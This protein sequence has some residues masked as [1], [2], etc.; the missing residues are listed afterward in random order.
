MIFPFYSL[1]LLYIWWVK[2]QNSIED[3]CCIKIVPKRRFSQITF[4]KLEFTKKINVKNNLSRRN[5]FSINSNLVQWSRH[6]WQN[7]ALVLYFLGYNLKRL[8]KFCASDLWKS[9]TNLRKHWNRPTVHRTNSCLKLLKNLVRV[10]PEVSY[11]GCSTINHIPYK[12][13]KMTSK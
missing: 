2:V 11:D 10:R 7:L 1:F 5:G 13:E 6:F 8:E 3:L 9:A 4:N 12:T